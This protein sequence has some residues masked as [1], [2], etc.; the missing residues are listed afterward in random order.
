MKRVPAILFLLLLSCSAY[1]QL[2]QRKADS[3]QKLIGTGLSDT[4]LCRA[5]ILLAE[6]YQEYDNNKTFEYALK[7]DSIASLLENKNLKANARLRMGMGH[8]KREEYYEAINYLFEAMQMGEELGEAN[9]HHRACNNL[10]NVYISMGQVE[11]ALKYF[12][13]AADIAQK[14]NDKLN[15]A[16]YYVNIG[17]CYKHLDKEDLASEF[18]F[19][20]LKSF[21]EMK[22]KRGIMQSYMNIATLYAA[23]SNL[24]DCQV[25][26]VKAKNMALEI[27]DNFSAALSY[28]NLGTLYLMKNDLDSSV[29]YLDS[30][31]HYSRLANSVRRLVDTYE[32]LAEVYSRK[33]DYR[34]A[35][36]YQRIHTHISDSMSKADKAEQV[37]SAEEKYQMLQHQKEIELGKKNEE[38]K[39]LRSRIWIVVLI[40]AVIVVGFAAMLL[41]NRN[42]RRQQENALLQQH[43]AMIT[44]QK[45]EI[46]DSINYAKRIQESILPPDNLVRQ[47]L[48]DSFVLYKPKDIV[49]GDFY[50]VEKKEDKVIFAAVD[51]T[52]HGVPGAM[53][54]VLGFNLLSQSVNERG[55]TRPG[56]ILQHL[57]FGVNQ[58]LRQSSEGNTVKDG[59]DLALCT[60]DVKTNELQF[61]GAYNGVWIIRRGAAGVEE[62]KGDKSP[63]GVNVDGIVDN[64]TNHSRQLAKGDT[65]YIFSDGYA[66]QFGGRDGKKF[67]YK[68]MKE[69]LLRVNSLSMAEQKAEL[70]KAI[71]AWQGDLEQVDDILVIGVRI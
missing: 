27:R 11:T 41:L 25:Y 23:D 24:A 45:K 31:L 30:A 4:A 58:M 6:V 12:L 38:I 42:K 69:L 46:T 34:K 55:L 56:D 2:D 5:Y 36:E 63:I 59:M 51:C 21:T 60:L 35:L 49:S 20:A 62:I 28:G 17:T 3:L 71:T 10:G 43:N 65:I 53:M 9:L 18:Y 15:M 47:L 29:V 70:D 67:K 14:V 1:S 7:A 16:R 48:P 13:K 52:G 44:H 8:F 64:Y 22:N 40:L 66:D 57:D 50:W 26:L 32:D 39:N 37:A 19:R 54:S 61:A 33:G 68:P